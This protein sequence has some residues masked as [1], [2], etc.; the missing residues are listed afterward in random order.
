MFNANV[1]LEHAGKIWWGDLDLT[2]DESQLANLAQQTGQTVYLLYESDGRFENEDAPLL[3]Q[4]VYSVTPSGHTRV[5][6][7]LV[8][9][10]ADGRLHRRPPAS[11][12]RWRRPDPP[13]LW[14]FW[15]L[16]SHHEHTRNSLGE[17]SSRLI[18]VGRRGHARRSPLLVLGVHGWEHDGRSRW[19]EWTWYPSGRRGWAPSFATRANWHWGPMR[20]FISLRFT[21]GIAHEV[22]IGI[23]V[24][25][26]TR[27][28]DRRAYDRTPTRTA[29]TTDAAFRSTEQHLPTDRR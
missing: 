27:H 17:R 25:A 7:T 13:R 23:T 20:P 10:R 18:Y 12:P 15:S 5:D 21:P 24:A 29:P 4:A 28:E 1:C 19:V 16:D 8:D 9:R 22:R 14:R 11:R 6:H 3:G 2:L 26:P